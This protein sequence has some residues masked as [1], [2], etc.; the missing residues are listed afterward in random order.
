METLSVPRYRSASV[1][2][3]G[4]TALRF[5]F[6]AELRNCPEPRMPLG[7]LGPTKWELVP[8]AV[9]S[10]LELQRDFGCSKGDRGLNDA[11]Q[12]LVSWGGRG[13]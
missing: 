2:L 12:S 13:L 4:G 6:L 5:P 11:E 1:K 9:L 3:G 8:R 7:S 10:D